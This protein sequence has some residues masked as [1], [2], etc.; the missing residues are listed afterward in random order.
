MHY[1]L[2]IYVARSLLYMYN[3]EGSTSILAGADFARS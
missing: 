2:G 3:D 1:V